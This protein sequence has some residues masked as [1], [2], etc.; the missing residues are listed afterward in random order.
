VFAS[1]KLPI[2]SY[3]L[4]IVIFCNKCKGKNALALSRDLGVQHKTAWVLGH[5][6]REAMAQEMKGQHIGGDGETVE[7]DGCY[8]GGYVKP[9]N[10]KEHRR[11]RRL[12]RNQNGKRKVVVVARERGGN[13]LTTVARTESASLRFIREI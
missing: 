1:H 6:L 11:D 3:L 7:I 10:F 4:A 8:F 12:A 9:A 5:K 13:I 2:R